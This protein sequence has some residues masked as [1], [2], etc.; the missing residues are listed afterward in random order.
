LFVYLG[1]GSPLFCLLQEQ[2]KFQQLF[3]YLGTGSPL[4]FLPLVNG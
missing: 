1:T 3:D 4:L 2:E